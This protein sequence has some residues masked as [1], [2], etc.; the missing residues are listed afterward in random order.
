MIEETPKDITP[1]KRKGIDI[2]VKGLK[3]QYPF[4]IGYEDDPTTQYESSH[5]IDLYIDLD[6]LSEYM[7]VEVNPY[8]RGEIKN[9][10]RYQKVFAIW[11]YLNFPPEYNVSSAN[12]SEHPGYK[13]G[14]EIKDT[15]ETIYQYLPDEYKL[16]YTS[17]TGWV[18]PPPIY[19]VR[20][21]A[22]GYIMT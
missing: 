8:W 4:V 13:L 11:T 3:K 12:V 15:L 10:P 16:Q 9:D 22:N 18:D 19:D 21:K 14:E 20:L 7:G 2:A 17:K 1:I 5:Y 6:E